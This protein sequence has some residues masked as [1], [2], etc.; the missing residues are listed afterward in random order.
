VRKTIGILRH[1]NGG[2]KELKAGDVRRIALAATNLRGP[3][4]ACAPVQL[5]TKDNLAHPAS[6]PF[7]KAHRQQS[8]QR[9]KLEAYGINID[10][11][12]D[13]PTALVE[14]S[15]RRYDPRHRIGA[16]P[17]YTWCKLVGAA[18]NARCTNWLDEAPAASHCAAGA[19]NAIWIQ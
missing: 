5:V 3:A 11:S 18:A 6:H 10:R 9:D 16:H 14:H 2:C 12:C 8:C 1:I 13:L 7:P 19:Q 15:T 4:N 17:D